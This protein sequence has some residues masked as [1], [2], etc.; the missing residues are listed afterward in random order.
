MYRKFR[1]M[2][3]WKQ[4]LDVS[5]RIFKLTD[6]LPRKEDYGLTS[7]IRR[8]ANSMGANIAEGFGR[9]HTREKTN[10]YVISR[11]SAYETI[12][13]I[14]YGTEIEYFCKEETSSIIKDL[15]GIIYEIN[16]MIKSLNDST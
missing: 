7:Q 15:E 5:V 9:R 4:A 14:L 1:D 10:F 13:H 11:G 12:H 8:S 16:K 6:N 3:I 2:P